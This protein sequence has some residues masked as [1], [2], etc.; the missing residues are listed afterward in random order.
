MMIYLS[1]K[2]MQVL[3][4]VGIPNCGFLTEDE[5]APPLES[6]TTLRILSKGEKLKGLQKAGL[7][8][9]VYDDNQWRVNK[10]EWELVRHPNR[11]QARL[12]LHESED[13]FDV[14]DGTNPVERH[15]RVSE[16]VLETENLK[17]KIAQLEKDLATKAKP[18]KRAKVTDVNKELGVT[19]NE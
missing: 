3:S 1:P 14:A 10:C 12:L 16:A 9:E 18:G 6:N 11:K 17:L 8:V 19:D 4:D 15:A 2:A 7:A 13:I 5:I